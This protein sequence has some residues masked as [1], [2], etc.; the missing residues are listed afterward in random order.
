MAAY[1]RMT[2]GHLWADCLYTGINSGPNAQYQV[3]EAFTFLL[4]VQTGEKWS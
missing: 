3:W 4:S 2:Y 1:R